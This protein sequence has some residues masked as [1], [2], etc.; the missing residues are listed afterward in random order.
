MEHMKTHRQWWC[1]KMRK[2]PSW[3]LQMA[4]MRGKKRRRS[5]TWKVT[6]WRKW[7]GCVSCVATLTVTEFFHPFLPVD[8][9]PVKTLHKKMIVDWC[10]HQWTHLATAEIT[11][12]ENIVSHCSHFGGDWKHHFITH[13]VSTVCIKWNN[14]ESVF[15]HTWMETISTK[16][17]SFDHLSHR[18]SY[19]HNPIRESFYAEAKIKIYCT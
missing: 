12:G 13:D 9:C 2:S 18:M 11:S 17:L 5:A 10:C 3:L 4:S 14:N 15:H 19:S 7:Q 8:D 16:W 1:P 6:R